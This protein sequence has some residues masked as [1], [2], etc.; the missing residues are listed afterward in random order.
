MADRSIDQILASLP[1]DEDTNK[2]L[3]F[4]LDRADDPEL[5][6][7]FSN[8]IVRN[9]TDIIPTVD[10]GGIVDIGEGMV[11]VTYGN[12]RVVTGPSDGLMPNGEFREEDA[13]TVVEVRQ[14]SAS[15][16][17]TRRY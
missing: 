10:N 6:D 17:R 3:N 8:R 15:P 1:D 13:E 16:G 2:L 4:L 5:A 9:Q 11:R 7:V 12:G 14:G